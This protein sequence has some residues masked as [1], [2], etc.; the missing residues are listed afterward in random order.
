ML[1]KELLKAR[2]M[3][4]LAR[5]YDHLADDDREL[6]T[7]EHKVYRAVKVLRAAIRDGV[8]LDYPE[9]MTMEEIRAAAT[10]ARHLM[11]DWGDSFDDVALFYYD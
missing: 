11:D 6:T 8:D 1:T 4:V 9:E 5:V 10:V 2:R 3:E 7:T